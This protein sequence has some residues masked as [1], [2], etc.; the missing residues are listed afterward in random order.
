MNQYGL[1]D[2]IEDCFD[3]FHTEGD[4]AVFYDLEMVLKNKGVDIVAALGA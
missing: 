4:N 2:L 1:L 3:T